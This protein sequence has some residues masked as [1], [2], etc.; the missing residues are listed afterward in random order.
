MVTSKIK[1]FVLSEIACME[2][3]CF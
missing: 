3:T 2:I 1:E